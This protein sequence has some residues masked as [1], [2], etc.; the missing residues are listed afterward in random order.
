[1]K[2]AAVCCTIDAIVSMAANIHDCGWG[3]SPAQEVHS[4]SHLAVNRCNWPGCILLASILSALSVFYLKGQD[5][6]V[7]SAQLEQWPKRCKSMW[8]SHQMWCVLGK[9]NNP[10]CYCCIIDYPNIRCWIGKRSLDTAINHLKDE[11]EFNIRWKPFLLNPVMPD[12][13]IPLMDYCRA[14]FGEVAAQ[15]FMSENS[16]I[17]QR[18]RELVRPNIRLELDCRHWHACIINEL[19]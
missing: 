11:F 14:K 2:P 19:S 8:T 1:M 9:L 10:S 16:P 13:G 4:A 6:W 18:G 12:E 5:N 15:R 7:Y 3:I 17:S